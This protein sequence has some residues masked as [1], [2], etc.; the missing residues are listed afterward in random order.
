[1]NKIILILATLTIIPKIYSMQ[2]ELK[3]TKFN[4]RLNLRNI[5]KQESNSDK[6]NTKKVQHFYSTG[7]LITL[8][9]KYQQDEREAITGQVLYALQEDSVI[10]YNNY[11]LWTT[12]LLKVFLISEI[13]VKIDKKSFKPILLRINYTDSK[14]TFKRLLFKKPLYDESLSKQTKENII[15]I[16][17][18]M[19]LLN[20]LQKAQTS[21][22]LL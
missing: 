21:P 14:N 10:N 11:K 13:F 9:E 1:M 4:L 8:K 2:P 18:K 19:R 6:A 15:L 12:N 20:D 22:E 3:K 7:F 16:T 5:N 17:N